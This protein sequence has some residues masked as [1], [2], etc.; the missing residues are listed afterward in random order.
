MT[1]YPSLSVVIPTYNRCA[2]VMALVESLIPQLHHDDELLV[3]DDGSKDETSITLRKISRVRLISNPTNLGMIKTWNICL[4]TASRDWICMIHD[5]DTLFPNTIEVIR[6]VC[7]SQNSPAL[8]GHQYAG[9]NTGCLQYRVSEPGSWA[10]L[11]PFP[12]PSGVTVHRD[13]IK[14]SGLFNEK[15]QYSPDIE[16]FSRI[17]KDFT[18]IS[19]ENPQILSFNL[20]S[21]NYEFKTWAKPDFL[22]NL[23]QIERLISAYAGL[24]EAEAEGYFSFKMNSYISYILRTS[25][26]SGDKTLLRK[27]GKNVKDRPY[28]GRRNRVS[29]YIAAL[30]NWTIVL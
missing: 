12:I 23:E 28:L 8:I 7:S 26:K 21:Q 15:F 5:D 20:H 29:S 13:I 6:R 11:N 30:L 10:A 22:S 1:R 4:T 24:S 18:S 25:P 2:S 14:A 17:C 27:I 3:I 19:I 9:K 16:Y